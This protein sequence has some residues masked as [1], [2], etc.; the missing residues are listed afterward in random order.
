M[1][2][3]FVLSNVSIVTV[4]VETNVSILASV[5]LNHVPSEGMPPPQRVSPIPSASLLLPISALSCSL[6]RA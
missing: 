4:A 3:S 5:H 6:Y 2:G 1:G